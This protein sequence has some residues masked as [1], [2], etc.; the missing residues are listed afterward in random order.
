MRR[1]PPFVLPV[2]L[3]L[4]IGCSA[5]I[6]GAEQDE[7]QSDSSAIRVG[8]FPGPDGAIRANYVVRGD[9]AIVGGDIAFPRLS[10][11][12]MSAAASSETPL[13]R[14][15]GG[16]VPYVYFEDLPFVAEVERGIA[17][18]NAV[19]DRTGVRFVKRTT[20]DDFLEITEEPQCFSFLGYVGGP[21]KL[22]LA[23][24]C[25]D[26][27]SAVVEH[28]LGHAL[29]LMHELQRSDRDSYVE[30]QWDNIVDGENNGLIVGQLNVVQGSINY[31][32]YDYDSVMHY[33]AYNYGPGVVV[34]PNVP[35][36]KTLRPNSSERDIV[37]DGISEGD[38]AGIAAMYA[39]FGSAGGTQPSGSC[40]IA[41]CSSF[42]MAEDECQ[43]FPSGSFKC[44]QGCLEA[45]AVSCS[46]TNEDGEEQEEDEFLCDDGEEAFPATFECD[47]IA[48]CNDGS[49]E[50]DCGAST[51]TDSDDD[52]PWGACTAD[53]EAG[54][55]LDTTLSTCLGTLH[56][57]A[58]PGPNE[59]RCCT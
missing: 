49:D 13:R 22:G 17:A 54:Q 5:T 12:S 40:S 11:L 30:F 47:A 37:V 6:G 33:G 4:A 25:M 50:A 8:N 52:N 28:E 23:Q 45:Q 16:V 34:D 44:E 7:P 31:S 55:C 10:A 14:W 1:I 48:D 51:G 36:Y 53:G 15:P 35:L 9:L 39:G 19:S 18:W 3:S 38:V 29:G 57:G 27:G 24:E 21:Q 42:N 20:E 26:L 32:D 2:L 56:T 41:A 59:I 46:G 43:D 58:C